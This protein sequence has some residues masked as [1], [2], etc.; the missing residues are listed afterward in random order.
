MQ[1]YLLFLSFS[2]FKKEMNKFDTDISKWDVAK[3]QNMEG[4][5]LKNL[6]NFKQ[7]PWCSKSW[8]DK[9]TMFAPEAGQI[10]NRVVCCAPGTFV[11]D[12]KPRDLATSS[13]CLKCPKGQYTN[14]LNLAMECK[15]CPRNTIAAA[16]R[17]STC[18]ACPDGT[19]SNDRIQCTVCAAG[20]FTLEN[21]NATQCVECAAGKYKED[22]SVKGACDVC[23]LGWNQP[24]KT[25]PFCLQC[26]R[27]VH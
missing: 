25:K 19:F 23:P 27:K 9:S 13:D 2:V 15:R 14:S 26:I 17:S 10:I 4:M 12:K 7:E 6:P 3:V 18:A 20:K 24:E 8:N 11:N 22:G 1:S 21:A 16:E 5:G